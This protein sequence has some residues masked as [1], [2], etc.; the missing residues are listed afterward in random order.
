MDSGDCLWWGRVVVPERAKG[1]GSVS[2]A[3]NT[4]CFWQVEHVG[5]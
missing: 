5:T 2:V 1:N 3:L 4:H